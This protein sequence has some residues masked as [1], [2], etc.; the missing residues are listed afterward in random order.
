M[1]T[2]NGHV[3]PQRAGLDLISHDV[4]RPSFEEDGQ[5]QLSIRGE[6]SVVD[7][8]LEDFELVEDLATG[9]GADIFLE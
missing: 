6:E 4:L 3:V 9:P 2:G 8:A 5:S 7:L 1:N